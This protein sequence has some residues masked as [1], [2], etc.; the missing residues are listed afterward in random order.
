MINLFYNTVIKF[1][2]HAFMVMVLFLCYCSA[3]NRNSNQP[4]KTITIIANYDFIMADNGDIIHVEDSFRVSYYRNL[5][6]YQIPEI[7]EVTKP[8]FKNDTIEE[9]VISSEIKYKYYMYKLYSLLGYKYDSL[10]EQS[11]R[12]F[13]VDSFLIAEAFAKFRFY[14]KEND[15]LV[16]RTTDPKTKIVTEKYI[17][18]TKYD[19][20]Y[21]DSSYKY[22]SD[23]ELRNVDF[24]FSKYLDSIRR[25]KLIKVP[26]VHNPIP[27]GKYAFDV[28]QRNLI[29]EL[30]KTVLT[31]SP[32]VIDFFERVKTHK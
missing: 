5:I 28:P 32:E 11:N 7:H 30:K 2:L 31:N 16:E 3:T 17:P 26:F 22:F 24:S 8:I 15:S 18:R 19:E 1:A 13:T 20:T 12:C 29:F 14:D 10:N 27:K 6:L 9:K 23:D 4:L 21:P 25:K